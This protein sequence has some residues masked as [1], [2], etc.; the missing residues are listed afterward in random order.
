M[1]SKIRIAVALA[2]YT[3]ILRVPL[4]AQTQSAP[5]TNEKVPVRIIVVSSLEQ[6]EHILH[7]LKHGADFALLARKKSIDATA[8]DG[9]YMG[10]VVIATLR[11]E[12]RAA[13]LELGPGDISKPVKTP[14]GYAVLKLLKEVPS[15]EPAGASSGNAAT[16][17]T[18]SVRYV[19]GVGG[20]NEA[21]LTLR[22]MSQ[23]PGWDPKPAAVCRI[24]QDPSY[25]QGLE[26]FLSP[27]NVFEL[28][29]KP[30]VD[31]LNAYYSLGEVNAFDG[32]MDEAINNTR[33]RCRS[34]LTDSPAQIPVQ[35]R[36]KYYLIS[37]MRRCAHQK[38][39]PTFDDIVWNIM[40]LLKNGT[41]PEH[42][43]ILSVLEE[44]A[45]REGHDRW[46]L[47]SLGQGELFE[48]ELET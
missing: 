21:E 43:T 27:Q 46:R 13:L 29:A 42:Q 30:A 6:A 22:K 4:R 18:G 24:K 48:K 5:N 17:S 40:P 36:I 41:T 28:A 11:P 47:K 16:A 2:L 14:L 19:F 12:I 3:A 23:Q 31:V 33:P 26:Q 15:N 35:V 10:N 9:G 37:Y 39:F 38:L 44:V 32:N 34:R 25:K 8:D 45:T 20:F 1:H 7:E